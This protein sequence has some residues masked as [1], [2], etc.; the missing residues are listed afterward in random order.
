MPFVF[1]FLMPLV[2]AM[3]YALSER[4]LS[5]SKLIARNKVTVKIFADI[6]E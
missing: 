4:A 2:F 5:Q 1:S 3:R 6:D